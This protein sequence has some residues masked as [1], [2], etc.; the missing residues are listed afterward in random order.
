MFHKRFPSTLRFSTHA[1]RTKIY[2]ES[3]NE[4][5]KRQNAPLPREKK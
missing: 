3:R 4:A 1:E 2:F 5:V